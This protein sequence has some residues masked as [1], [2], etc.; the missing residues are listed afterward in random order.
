MSDLF[1][2]TAREAVALLRGLEV[3]PLD[4]I[5]AAQARIEAIDSHINAVRGRMRGASWKAVRRTRS[6][7]S[8]GCRSS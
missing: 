5:A 7:I 2:L 1:R 6:V 8:M 4:L 3:S